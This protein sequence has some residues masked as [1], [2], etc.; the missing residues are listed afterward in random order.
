MD[1]CADLLA[2]RRSARLACREYNVTLFSQVFHKQRN[3]RGLTR[4]F[5]TF[6]G[7]EHQNFLSSSKILVE[8]RFESVPKL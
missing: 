5:W 1:D 3:M 8:Q 6:K 4:T 2:N 7:D